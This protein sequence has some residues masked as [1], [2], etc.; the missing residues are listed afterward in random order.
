MHD[1][2]FVLTG[3][4]LIPLGCIVTDLHTKQGWKISEHAA[5]CDLDK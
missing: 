1:K 3:H 2:R 5:L 4:I